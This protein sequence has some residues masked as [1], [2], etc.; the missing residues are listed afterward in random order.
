VRARHCS[1]LFLGL[2]FLCL[3][4]GRER[5]R[6][7]GIAAKMPVISLKLCFGAIIERCAAGWGPK[8]LLMDEEEA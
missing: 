4:E 3:F 7:L 2:C 5:E 1:S 8:G 6:V